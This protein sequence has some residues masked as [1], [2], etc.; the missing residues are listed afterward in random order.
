MWLSINRT[1]AYDNMV[2]WIVSNLT[3]DMGVAGFAL[4]GSAIISPTAQVLA[5]EEEKEGAI[6]SEIDIQEVK[7]LKSIYPI[8]NID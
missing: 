4:G 3:K 8:T 7:Y 1:R 6:Y 2:Y 5:Y